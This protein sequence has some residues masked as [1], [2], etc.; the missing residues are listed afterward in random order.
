MTRAVVVV[1]ALAA[2]AHAQTPGEGFGIE[3]FRAGIDGAALL[4]VDWADVPAHGRWSFGA[5]SGLAHDPLVIYDTQMNAVEALVERRV[6]T[7]LVGSLALWDRVELAVATDIVGYQSGAM[8]LPTSGLGDLSLVGKVML[9]RGGGFAVAFVPAFGVPL[10]SATGYLREAGPTLA[11]E[12]AASMTSGLFRAS[13]NAGYLLRKRVETAGLVVDNE[14]YARAA[15]GVNVSGTELMW[16][17]SAARPRHDATK[18]VVAVETLIGAGRPI[19]SALAVFAAGGVGLDNGFGT[20]D[21][22]AVVGVR[23]GSAPPERAP[24][25]VVEP[26]KPDVDSDGDGILDKD[27]RCP[28]EPEDKDG[29]Q[30]ADGCPDLP[31][32]LAGHVTDPDGRP[33][34]KAAVKIEQ[35]DAAG[36]PAIELVT[37]DDGAFATTLDGGAIHLSAQAPEYQPGTAEVRV[38]PGTP[39]TVDVKLVR[40]VRQGQLRGEVLSYDGK[41]LAATISVTGKTTSKATADADGRYTVDLPEGAYEVEIEAPG[42]VTQRRTVSVKLD[43]VTVL[44]VDLRGAK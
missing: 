25:V 30:D 2:S 40:A 10:G 5:W 18:N 15:L 1:A 37:G 43:G 39:G 11:P 20:P 19:S 29:F 8:S 33:I 14:M 27:D 28:K 31:T 22:R 7:G 26:P 16:S 4:D 21:W 35:L 24:M 32:R 12:L 34:A 41:P 38:T 17:A 13:V 6:T 36:K 9:A 23:F 42:F 3:R 44:N